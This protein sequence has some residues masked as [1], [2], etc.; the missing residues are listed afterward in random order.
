MKGR[1]GGQFGFTLIELVL[2]MVI[3]AILAGM[4]APSIAAF[5]AGRATDNLGRRVVALAQY[6][7]TEAIAEGATYRLNFD[8][9]LRNF[10]L[11]VDQDGIYTAPNNEYGQHFS[12]PDGVTLQMQSSPQPNTQLLQPDN[13]QQDSVAQSA[14]LLNGTQA[15]TAGQVMRN[16]HSDGL[17]IE[18]QPT[19]RTDPASLVIT[20]RR[21]SRIEVSCATPSDLFQIVPAQGAAR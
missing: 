14:T 1:E 16:T 10:W 12:V 9:N 11:T 18:F 6:A 20:D 17:Y 4:L 19:G 13:I 21:G 7:R 15:G 5:G 2:V 8:S 3:V